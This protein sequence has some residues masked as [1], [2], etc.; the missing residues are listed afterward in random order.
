[1]IRY[2]EGRG[3]TGNQKMIE[4]RRRGDLL[5]HAVARVLTYAA[6]AAIGATAVFIF[7]MVLEHH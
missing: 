7:V 5:F 4:P 6:F 2:V 3:W 1:M